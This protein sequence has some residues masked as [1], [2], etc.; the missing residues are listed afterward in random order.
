MV[1]Q[2]PS[3]INSILPLICPLNLEAFFRSYRITFPIVTSNQIKMTF[4]I[5]LQYIIT[6]T[7]LLSCLVR[8]ASKKAAVLVTDDANAAIEGDFN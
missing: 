5:D 3:K 8:T 1:H 2:N 7:D 6:R 4:K